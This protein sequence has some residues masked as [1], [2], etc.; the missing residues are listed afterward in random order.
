M[1]KLYA[2]VRNIFD[3]IS[4]LHSSYELFSGDNSGLSL[5]AKGLS[6]LFT[7]KISLCLIFQ[8]INSGFLLVSLNQSASKSHLCK[9]SEN[10]DVLLFGSVENIKLSK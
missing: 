1:L 2:H 4:K 5:W 7:S 10:L 8:I 6:N 9:A 3:S